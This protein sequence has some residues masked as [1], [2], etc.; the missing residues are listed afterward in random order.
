MQEMSWRLV[1][2]MV[3]I[4]LQAFSCFALRHCPVSY[5]SSPSYGSSCSRW[6]L[7]NLSG[8]LVFMSS[9][10]EDPI[11]T[12]MKLKPSLTCSGKLELT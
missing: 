12:K 9:G 8:K 11:A 5:S 1:T 6:A 3:P 4:L 10:L 7:P 2:Q